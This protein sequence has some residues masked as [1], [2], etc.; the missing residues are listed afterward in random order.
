MDTVIR[1]WGNS[2]AVRLPM[3]VINQARFKP[4]QKVSITTEEGRIIIEPLQTVAYSLEELVSGITAKNAHAEASFG[5][6]VGKEL[7]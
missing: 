5:A 1:K 4:E 6:P 7:L 2:L 3:S